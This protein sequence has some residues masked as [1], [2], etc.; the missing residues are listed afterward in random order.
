MVKGWVRPKEPHLGSVVGTKEG[1]AE[2]LVEGFV[3]GSTEGLEEGI[4]KRHDDGILEGEKVNRT[5][6]T[7]VGLFWGTVELE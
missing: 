5:V 3:V 1:L 2:G 6:G 4:L 7:G